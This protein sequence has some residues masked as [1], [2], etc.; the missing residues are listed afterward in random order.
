MLPARQKK[1]DMK[2]MTEEERKLF[3]LYGK[4]PTHKNVLT[5]M[6]KDRKYF[7]SGDYA[8]SKAGASAGSPVGTAIPHPENIP[9]ASPPA[10]QSLSISPTNSTSPMSLGK[11]NTSPTL[12]TNLAKESFFEG[13]DTPS[14][15]NEP[16]GEDPVTEVPL[17]DAAMDDAAAAA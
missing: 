8:L 1:V 3:A 14:P 16:A 17:A 10:Q 15:S 11:E 7:D 9:H 13:G 2:S 12:L 4:L 6:Q 5:K